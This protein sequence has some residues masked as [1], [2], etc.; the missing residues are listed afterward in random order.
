ME[1][2]L[3]DDQLM[4]SWAAARAAAARTAAANRINAY[5]AWK[6]SSECETFESSTP[7]PFCTSCN[8]A[9]E[10]KLMHRL[11]KYNGIN[12]VLAKVCIDCTTRINIRSRE[13]ALSK[14]WEQEEN[15]QIDIFLRGVA[16]F[17]TSLQNILL[18]IYGYINHEIKDEN[19]YVSVPASIIKECIQFC[20][21]MNKVDKIYNSFINIPIWIQTQDSILV[22]NKDA[23]IG[24]K[25]YWSTA[26][27]NSAVRLIWK[28]K[29]LNPEKNKISFRLGI[30]NHKYNNLLEGFSIYVKDG[31]ICD[32]TLGKNEVK[33]KHNDIVSVMLVQ[34]G[35]DEGKVKFAINGKMC[36][37]ELMIIVDENYGNPV[38]KLGIVFEHFFGI[39][40]VS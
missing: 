25:K 17:K 39:Q 19:L 12:E 27:H 1:T 9:T 15:R 38:Y 21:D 20:Y 22:C 30:T 32:D 18:L 37:S 14:M 26:T 28:I 31:V 16:N 3:T 4:Q 8:G 34:S 24:W 13:D 33:V 10:L 2:D 29:I 11:C 23:D 36:L 7:Q 6:C 5:Y 35:V 40:I